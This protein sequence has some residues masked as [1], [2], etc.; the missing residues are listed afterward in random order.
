MSFFLLEE[1]EIVKEGGR[2]R[3]KETWKEIERVCKQVGYIS[4]D[5]LAG[6]VSA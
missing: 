3:E 6:R 4:S 5:Y 2:Q 1:R